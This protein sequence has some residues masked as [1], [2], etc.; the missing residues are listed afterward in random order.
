[1]RF[2][3]KEYIYTQKG[4]HSENTIYN[5]TSDIHY[6]RVLSH[7]L[8]SNQITQTFKMVLI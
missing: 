2:I 3:N 4:R 5:A 7:L 6:M 1:M 8:I